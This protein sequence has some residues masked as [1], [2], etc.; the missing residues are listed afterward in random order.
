MLVLSIM[1]LAEIKKPAYEVCFR[2]KGEKKSQMCWIL[3][4]LF[5]SFAGKVLE[6]IW[7]SIPW[8]LDYIE[9]PNWKQI[10]GYG[11]FFNLIFRQL[12][13]TVSAYCYV[14]AFIPPDT[15]NTNLRIIHYILVTS[16]FIG[17]GFILALWLAKTV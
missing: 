17:E 1:V 7:W 3:M 10:H 9:H 8:V 14:R 12:F 4:G 2:P 11:V 13:F 6:S 16:L 15:S 5:F